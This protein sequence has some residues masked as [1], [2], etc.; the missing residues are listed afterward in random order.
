MILGEKWSQIPS[1]I[2]PAYFGIRK[3][4]IQEHNKIEKPKVCKD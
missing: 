1:I 2:S 4:F 3:I